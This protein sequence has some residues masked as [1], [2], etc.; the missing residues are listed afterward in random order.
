MHLNIRKKFVLSLIA[1]GVL[2]LFSWLTLS[3][4]PMTLHDSGL[5]FDV[6][7]RF[8]LAVLVL[9]GFMAVMTSLSFWRALVQERRESE[10]QQEMGS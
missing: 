6:Q 8:R 4:D 5:G 7:I 1:F 10:E 2:G 3:N 9:L